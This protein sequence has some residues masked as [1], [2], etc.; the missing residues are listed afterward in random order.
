MMK[1][2][3][4]DLSPY[5]AR[6]RMQIYAKGITDIALERPADFGMPSFRKRLPIGRIPV[7]DIDGDL[8]PESE[9]IAEYI[10]Q[11]YPE[12]SLLGATPRET[13]HIRTIARIGD[14]Y[15]MNNM[16]MLSPQSRA[17]NRD[18][19]VVDLLGGQ[20][21]RNIKALD[22]MIGTDGYAC[23]GRITLADCALVPA[24]FMVE[25]VLPG[26][27]VENPIPKAENVAAWWAAIQQNEHAA[28]TL[29]ELHRGLEE[30]R[31]LIRSGAFEKMMAAAKAAMETA[32]Q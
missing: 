15:L 7:L 22:K 13:A 32:E 24:L 19:G 18:Q 29:A 17:A 27:G 23:A 4:G 5:S 11:I 16:F 30:R 8:M 12:P 2:Y 6:V 31:E 3:S 21:V 1:L 10:E 20:V 26:T 28:K 9:V 14:V 25:N